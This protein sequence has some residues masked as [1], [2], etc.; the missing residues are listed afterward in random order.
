FR[1]FADAGR[2]LAD[3]HLNYETV[4]PHP[5][6]ETWAQGKPITYRVEKMRLAKDKTALQVNESLTLTGIPPEAFAY[7]LG[8][9]SAVEWV[10]DQY[11]TKTD[12]R[13]GITSDPNQYSADERY[14]TD[15]VGRVVAVSLQTQ[16][17][18]GALPPL[19]GA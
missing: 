5:L 10:I 9:R 15:L 7:V 4:A 12:T 3:L 6:Q 19:G 1:Q 13:S 8:N 2:A 17:I 16:T 14:I 11:Q 18:I